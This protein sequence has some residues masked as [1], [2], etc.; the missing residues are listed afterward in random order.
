MR[1]LLDTHVMVWALT[2]PDK[3]SAPAR[4]LIENSKHTLLIS[5]VTPW[6]ISIKYRL[7]KLPQGESILADYEQVLKHFGAEELTVSSRH[8]ITSGAF[9]QV[10]R[11]PF[12]RLL[13]AQAFVERVSLVTA[14]AAFTSFPITSIW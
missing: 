1:I 5:A 11:D 6:E 10:H 2:S 13:A 7:G 14:D 12:D 8:A 4:K 9:S 3:L